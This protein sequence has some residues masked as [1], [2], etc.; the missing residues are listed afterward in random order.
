MNTQLNFIEAPSDILSVVEKGLIEQKGY[1]TC[2]ISEYS[3]SDEESVLKQLSEAPWFDSFNDPIE[4]ELKRAMAHLTEF[5]VNMSPCPAA[6]ACYGRVDVHYEETIKVQYSSDLQ[7]TE[8]DLTEQD[9]HF[10]THDFISMLSSYNKE[11]DSTK[12]YP[13][14]VVSVKNMSQP[15]SCKFCNGTGKISCPTCHG[16]GNG[17]CPDCKGYGVFYA[18]DNK[19][20]GYLYSKFEGKVYE[21]KSGADCPTCKGMGLFKCKRCDETGKI[22][23]NACNG[24]GYEKGATSAQEITFVKTIYSPF[25]EGELFLPN[26]ESM[27]FDVS[28]V[29]EQLCGMPPTIFGNGTISAIVTNHDNT[30]S[31]EEKVVDLFN[32]IAREKSLVGLTFLPYTLSRIHVVSFIYDDEEFFIVIVG[33]HAFAKALPSMTMKEVLFKTYKKKI[34]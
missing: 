16:I 31:P 23:C 32:T 9:V 13:E 20:K 26:G 7:I 28:M 29:K 5:R 21:L 12:T 33:T 34:R 6:L 25:M 22:S 1:Y 19:K 17:E 3:D 14:K 11:M 30:D 10:T 27:D 8:E 15:P 4:K 24:T 2:T 18:R